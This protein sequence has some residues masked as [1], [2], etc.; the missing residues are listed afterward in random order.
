MATHSLPS[1]ALATGVLLTIAACTPGVRP[2]ELETV[3]SI[4]DTA[5]A[6]Q[7]GD[8]LVFADR[9]GTAQVA[10]LPAPLDIDGTPA[11]QFDAGDVA[12]WPVGHSVVVFL[13]ARAAVPGDELV[14]NGHVSAG[15]DDLVG[16]DRDCVVNVSG[17]ER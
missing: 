2:T 16:C 1:A 9:M 11:R 15:L 12:Y 10:A 17:V 8:Q 7:L 3:F 5:V 4:S 14:V 13:Y 6:E